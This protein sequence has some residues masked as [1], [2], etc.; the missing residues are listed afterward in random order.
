[1]HGG[2]LAR[3]RG[4]DAPYEPVAG[5]GPPGRVAGGATRARPAGWTAGAVTP[6]P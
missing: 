6:P 5:I 1:M 4:G 3:V 2:A